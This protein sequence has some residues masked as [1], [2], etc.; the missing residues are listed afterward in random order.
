MYMTSSYSDD[1]FGFII[2]DRYGNISPVNFS[3]SIVRDK[4]DSRSVVFTGGI[5]TDTRK[6]GYYTMQVPQIAKNTVSYT[7][8]SGTYYLTGISHA[9][10]YVPPVGTDFSFLPDYNARYTVLAGDAFLRQ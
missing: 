1:A 9:S 2:R 5:F 3:G 10:L 8:P 7:D 4:E 6:S